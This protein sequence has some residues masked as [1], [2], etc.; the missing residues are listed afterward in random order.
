MPEEA[1]P[2]FSSQV[3]A[4]FWKAVAHSAPRRSTF[5]RNPTGSS[6]VLE[7]ELLEDR[8]SRAD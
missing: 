5:V 3:Q 6:A 1:L 2:Q 4:F 7:G 8:L